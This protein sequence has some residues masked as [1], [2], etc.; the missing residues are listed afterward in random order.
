[1]PARCLLTCPSTPPSWSAAA[2]T[3]GVMYDISLRT[4]IQF[5]GLQLFGQH[6]GQRVV[7]L[8][9]VNSWTTHLK[10]STASSSTDR[11]RC[12]SSM[13]ILVEQLD[14]QA[15]LRIGTDCTPQ[16]SQSTWSQSPVLHVQYIPWACQLRR[17]IYSR[18]WRSIIMP[19]MG[20]CAGGSCN[21][22]SCS[23]PDGRVNS[24]L[25]AE[26]QRLYLRSNVC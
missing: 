24:A 19:E 7:T 2:I 23:L 3:S 22:M 17:H 21:E 18:T 10:P 5:K 1:M 9:C 20:I 13:F 4:M 15:L 12:D 8:L 25:H 11:I 16:C 14:Q 26:T 6:T